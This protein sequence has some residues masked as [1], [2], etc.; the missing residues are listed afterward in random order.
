MHD[1]AILGDQGACYDF[2]VP[3]D[4]EISLFFVDLRL[5]KGVEVSG[6]E[7]GRIAGHLPRKVRQA[8]DR[9]TVM[10]DDFA[11]RR[12]LDVSAALRCQVDDHGTGLHAL[13]HRLGYQSSA[14]AGLE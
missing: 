2:V 10:L 7:G 14:R 1:L 13:H 5:K 3:F 4:G 12:T 6:V 9:H 11:R 8:H